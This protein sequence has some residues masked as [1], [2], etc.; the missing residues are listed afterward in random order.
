M[1]GVDMNTTGTAKKKLEL[2]RKMYFYVFGLT[3]FIAM[4]V[5]SG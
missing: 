1:K 2:I 5:I 4:Y 3:T